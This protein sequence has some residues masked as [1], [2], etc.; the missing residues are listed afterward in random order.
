MRTNE[1]GDTTDV[2]DI[3]DRVLPG[4]DGSEQL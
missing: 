4:P 3:I 2:V 1:N